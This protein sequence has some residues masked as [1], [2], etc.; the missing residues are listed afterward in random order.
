M[1]QF[2]RKLNLINLDDSISK[3][4]IVILTH[5]PKIQMKEGE[6]VKIE[7]K[8]RGWMG[9]TFTEKEAEEAAWGRRVGR[10]EEKEPKAKED[11]EDEEEDED[12]RSKRGPRSLGRPPPGLKLRTVWSPF[13]ITRSMGEGGKRRRKNEE[14]K[15][16][17]KKKKIERDWI[18]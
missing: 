16:G 10:S 4:Q 8:K 17:K 5:R 18:G 12:E 3:S 1:D 11:E 15:G 13:C 14:E 2:K 9:R 7:P 6:L